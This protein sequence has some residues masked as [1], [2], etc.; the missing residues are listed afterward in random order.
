MIFYFLFYQLFSTYSSNI[1]SSHFSSFLGTVKTAFFTVCRFERIFGSAEDFYES[2][3]EEEIA[4]EHPNN[5]R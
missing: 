4:S 3:F 5:G 2:Y 1:L